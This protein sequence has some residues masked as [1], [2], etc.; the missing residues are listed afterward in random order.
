MR[1]AR[2]ISLLAACCAL[3]FATSTPAPS[4]WVLWSHLG[5]DN[6]AVTSEGVWARLP[7]AR[8]RDACE[9]AARESAPEWADAGGYHYRQK[10]VCLPDSVDPRGPKTK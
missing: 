10:L 9:R 4:T 3:T 2:G 1:L 6:P 8:E 5:S 7:Q